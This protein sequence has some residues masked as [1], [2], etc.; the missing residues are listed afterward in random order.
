L[1]HL[2]GWPEITFSLFFFGKNKENTFLAPLLAPRKMVELNRGG[3]RGRAKQGAQPVELKRRKGGSNLDPHS[4]NLTNFSS[5]R[6]NFRP[7]DKPAW[8]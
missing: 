8:R 3:T 2:F 1:I 4:P 6:R 7:I 5:P